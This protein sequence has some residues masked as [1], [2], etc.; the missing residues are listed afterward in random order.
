MN[1]AG[2]NNVGA[3]PPADQSGNPT[4]VG[5]GVPPIS[6]AF[7]G[8]PDFSSGDPGFGPNINDAVAALTDPLF[9]MQTAMN[10]A[11]LGNQLPT[12]IDPSQFQGGQQTAGGPATSFQSN[13]SA[14]QSPFGNDPGIQAIAKAL[15]PQK[16][17]SRVPQ[18]P[19]WLQPQAP[20]PGP[21]AGP[22]QTDILS[23]SQHE[24]GYGLDQKT[25]AQQVQSRYPQ[26]PPP[27]PMPRPRPESA[28]QFPFPQPRPA[29]APQPEQFGPPNLDAPTP[30]RTVTLPAS[31]TPGAAPP[32]TAPP[33][34]P[35]A[36]APAQQ[37][38]PQNPIQAIF[39]ALGI[40]PGVASTLAHIIRQ[41]GPAYSGGPLPGR[42]IPLPQTPGSTPVRRPEE[43]GTPGT[44]SDAQNFIASR[45][46]HSAGE[47]APNL[48]PEFADRVKKA[49][50]AYEAET[51]KRA[52]FTEMGR[53]HERQ[54]EYYEEYKHGGGISAPPYHSRHEKGNAVDVPHGDFQNW[55]HR[56]ASRF[57]IQDLSNTSARA[58]R[59]HFQMDPN[60]AGGSGGDEQP[61]QTTTDPG[62]Y[63]RALIERES[64]GNPR[65]R[66]GSNRGLIQFGP[67]EERKY[68]HDIPP[69]Q[70]HQRWAQ[71]IGLQRESVD[72]T[73]ILRRALGRDPTPAELYLTHQQGRGGGPALLTADANTPAWQ[74][75]RQFYR[76]DAIAQKAIKGNIP[77]DNPLRYIPVWQITAGQF[78]NMWN[79]QFTR[80]YSMRNAG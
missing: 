20:H 48:N 61:K 59:N 78:R 2:N 5:G 74:V 7:E 67:Q 63:A 76:S 24:G 31:Q 79:D 35:P 42:Q 64:S 4:D 8:T 80:E 33:S 18:G 58:D 38:S 21:S 16:D 53:S 75:L 28:P 37:Q 51:G 72:H 40:P 17:Q 70:R 65:E 77:S 12:G 6:G 39:N 49:A 1:S 56:N 47:G 19:T 45:G 29:G 25:P 3:G 26:P 32:A 9:G 54:A 41:V 55:M 36:A 62:R 50:E 66:T 11:G 10:Q 60:F 73:N 44:P 23:G 52:E 27:T 68:M 22:G 13:Q 46:G 71:L 57:G 14:Q 43:T 30:V 69:S 34:A 15:M